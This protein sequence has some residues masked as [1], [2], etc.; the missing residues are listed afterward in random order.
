[1]S[2]C[3]TLTAINSLMSG[4]HVALLNTS[5]MSKGKSAELTC[6]EDRWATLSFFAFSPPPAKYAKTTTALNMHVKDRLAYQFGLW[7]W[8]QGSCTSPPALPWSAMQNTLPFWEGDVSIRCPS[9]H[10]HIAVKPLLCLALNSPISPGSE[11]Y[12]AG[13]TTHFSES[14]LSTRSS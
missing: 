2:Y 6:A 9:H 1:M 14:S 5:Q 3:T 11:P 10:M 8:S 13:T 4:T 12:R 7:T